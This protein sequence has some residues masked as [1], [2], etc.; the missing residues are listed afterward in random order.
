[1]F[2]VHHAVQRGRVVRVTLVRSLHTSQEK[3]SHAVHSLT[4]APPRALEALRSRARTN[5][6][7]DAAA[8]AAVGRAAR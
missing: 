4:A 1:M 3:S 6:E 7:F 8:A 2:G 5:H